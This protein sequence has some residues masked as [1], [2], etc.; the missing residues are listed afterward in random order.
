MVVVW[1]SALCN[2][3]RCVQRDEFS[4]ISSLPEGEEGMIEPEPIK[5]IDDEEESPA[6][7]RRNLRALAALGA[8]AIVVLGCIVVFLTSKPQ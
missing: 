5:P 2:G 3:H 8:F 7:R 1:G 4:A 6:I